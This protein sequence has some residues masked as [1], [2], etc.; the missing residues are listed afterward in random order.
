MI[1]FAGRD[2]RRDES[3]AARHAQVAQEGALGET[4]QEIFPPALQGQDWLTCQ[5]V[6]QMAGHGPAQPS[7]ADPNAGEAASFQVRCEATADGFDFGQ[8]GHGRQ[9]G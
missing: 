8:F 3:K 2:V 1:V 4:E 6:A 7:V 5:E 9:S